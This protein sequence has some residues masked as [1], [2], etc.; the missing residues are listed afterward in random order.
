MNPDEPAVLKRTPGSRERYTCL[1][2]G[3]FRRIYLPGA[4]FVSGD[5]KATAH[6]IAANEIRGAT[7]HVPEAA[8]GLPA[9]G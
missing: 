3:P 5:A 2:A 7:P 9:A 4:L 6:N 8:A 1:L